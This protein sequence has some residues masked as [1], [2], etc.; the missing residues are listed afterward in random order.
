MTKL[1]ACSVAKQFAAG[2]NGHEVCK[3]YICA[4]KTLSFILSFP[5]SFFALALFLL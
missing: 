3:H 2:S 1:E 5:S 4:H